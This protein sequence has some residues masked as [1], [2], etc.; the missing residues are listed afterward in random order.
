MK[1]FRSL[2]HGWRLLT[3][4]LELPDISTLNNA[5]DYQKSHKSIFLAKRRRL[6]TPVSHFYW[7][8]ENTVYV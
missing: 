1:K 4:T 7:G 2:S 3:V 8:A 5:K 6:E